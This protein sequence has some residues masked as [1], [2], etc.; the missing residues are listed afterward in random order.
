LVN[1]ID[2]GQWRDGTA[3]SAMNSQATALGAAFSVAPASFINF[4]PDRFL[5]P[6]DARD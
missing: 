2:T 4:Q 3:P 5:R 1:R 6:F